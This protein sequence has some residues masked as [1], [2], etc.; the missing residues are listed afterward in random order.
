MISARAHHTVRQLTRRRGRSILTIITI[1]VAI[2]GVWMFAIPGNIRSV[3]ADRVAT[4][5][6]HTARLAPN[7]APLD[8]DQLA[9]LRTVDNVA[10][11]DTRTLARDD[12]RVDGRIEGVVLVGVDDFE[13]QLVNIVALQEGTFPAAGELVTD[14]DNARTGRLPLAVGDT[15]DLRT[16]TGAFE[17]FEVTGR[18]GTLRYSSEVRDDAPVLYLPSAEVQRIMGYPAANS[19]DVLAVDPSP[20]A[21]DAMVTDLRA[22]LA[23][24]IADLGYWD[25]LEVW[26]ADTWPG[27]EDVG[28]FVVVFYVIAAVALLSA[29]VLIFTTMNTVVREQTREIGVMKAIGGTPRAIATGYLRAA[30]VLGA[31][32]TTLGIAIGFPLSNALMQFMSSEFGG[33]D[34]G[35]VLSWVALVLSLVFGL[36]G[37]ALASLPAVRHASRITVRD[38]IEDHGVLASYGTRPLDRF[39]ARI[40]ASRRSQMG[41]RNATRRAGR[42]VATA[43]PIALA[44]GT[45]L[46]FGS[47]LITLVDV[48]QRTFDLEGADLILWDRAPGL[49]AEAGEL[50]ATVPEVASAHPMTYSSVEL[51]GE[52]YVWG[53]PAESTYEPDLV[54]GRWYTAEEDAAAARVVVVGVAVANQNGIDVGDMITVETRGGPLEL[55]VIGIDGQLVN[56]AEGLFIPFE[57][58]LDYEGRST[59]N[60]WIRTVDGDPATVD[61][62]ATAIH[63]TLESNGYRLESSRRYIDRQQ[64][65]NEQRL[66]VS[67]VM[68]MGLPIVAIGM[69]G[70]VGATASNVI[71]RT[72]EIG[73]LR[74]IGARRRDLR[75]MFRMEGLVIGALGWLMG[76][77][78]GYALAQ[79][80]L[81]VFERRFDAAFGFQFPLWTIAVAL[82]VTLMTTVIVMRFPL[83]RAVH[84]APGVALRYE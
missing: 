81:W 26:R 3:L 2:A 37:T 61:A 75:V 39:A 59:G 14:T 42:T 48:D 67:V 35:W 66:I 45:L 27:S 15:I 21:V 71:D 7:A 40:P 52:K 31:I 54:A 34:V 30:L 23:D 49:D 82:A 57:T 65:V 73:I 84:L 17:T 69:I 10:A 5:A 18:G 25:V 32:G 63:G 41:I 6:M 1:A 28:N 55:E 51:D 47:A 44:V 4:D 80:I 58:V 62:A 79:L 72:R 83:R 53:L 11:L 19:I 16:T 12:M 50:I 46:G 74:S 24:E 78:A 29:L 56:N 76:I 36:G 22:I 33:A 77:P 9:E 70:L 8:A 64:N 38:A 20:A 60:W 13:Q 68:A 43:V